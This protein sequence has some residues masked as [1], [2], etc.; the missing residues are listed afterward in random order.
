MD[1]YR[2]TVSPLLNEFSPP[3]SPTRCVVHRFSTDVTQFRIAT[4]VLEYHM[5]GGI[6]RKVCIVCYHSKVHCVVLCC[7]AQAQ[8]GFRY[9]ECDT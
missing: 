3:F 9:D 1:L 6:A 8:I 2:A 5:Q 7:L 4:A